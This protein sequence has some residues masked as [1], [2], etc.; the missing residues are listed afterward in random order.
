MLHKQVQLQV[1]KISKNLDRHSLLI[2]IFD[3]PVTGAG[4]PQGWGE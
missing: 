3:K 2:S 4:P 1:K